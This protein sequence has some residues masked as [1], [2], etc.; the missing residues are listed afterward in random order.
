MRET[1]SERSIRSLMRHHPLQRR[2]HRPTSALEAGILERSAKPELPLLH[3]R[4]RNTSPNTA[5]PS[6]HTP[7]KRWLREVR[8]TAATERAGRQ[9]RLATLFQPRLRQRCPRRHQ[10]EVRAR[11]AQ[12]VGP[13]RWPLRPP[14]RNRP[15]QC[16]G[17]QFAWS[18]ASQRLVTQAIGFVQMLHSPSLKQASGSTMSH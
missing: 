11:R 18:E 17:R 7:R 16:D 9:R 8:A 4:A 3:P 1:Q 15:R 5:R 13:K 14:R 12:Q 10:P 2:S 6:S